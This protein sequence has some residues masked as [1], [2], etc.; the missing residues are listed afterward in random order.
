MASYPY[1]PLL[2]IRFTSAGKIRSFLTQLAAASRIEACTKILSCNQRNIW[3]ILPS[4]RDQVC[5]L[6]LEHLRNVSSHVEA[7]EAGAAR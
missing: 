1:Q 2:A 6:A 4:P 7:I 3:I 5:Y